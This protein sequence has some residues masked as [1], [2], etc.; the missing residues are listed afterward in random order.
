MADGTKV[1]SGRI[2]WTDLTVPDAETV[3]GFYSAVVGWSF[4]PVRMAG[5]DDYTMHPSGGGDPVAGICHARGPNAHLPPQWLVYVAV[6]DLDHAVRECRRLGGKVLDGPRSMGERR[7]C[8]IQD[9]AG[10]CL[11]LVG[12]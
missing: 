9:P 12:P 1:P 3:R 4:E 5:Y 8:L 6:G 10:A 11:A 2:V 7:F